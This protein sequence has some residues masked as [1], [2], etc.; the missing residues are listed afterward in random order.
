MSYCL[1]SLK[2]IYIGTAL[3]VIKGH[4]RSL[5]DGLNYLSHHN[6]YL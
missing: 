5:A 1:S 6:G 3:G 4:T 2:G